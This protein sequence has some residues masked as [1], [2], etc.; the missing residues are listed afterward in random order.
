[1]AEYPHRP[2][3]LGFSLGF[4]PGFPEPPPAPDAPKVP[5]T[6]AKGGTVP[7]IGDHRPGVGIVKT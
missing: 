2:W 4:G 5:V 7:L 1:M 6:G 3:S